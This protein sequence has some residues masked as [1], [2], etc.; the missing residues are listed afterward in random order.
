MIDAIIYSKVLEAKKF[1]VSLVVKKNIDRPILIN[2]LDLAVLLANI[3]D[4]AI[5][6]TMAVESDKVITL[7]LLTDNDNVIILSQNPTINSFV[8]GKLKTT[9]RDK[10]HHGFGTL[11]INSIAEKYNGRYIIDFNNGMAIV[12]VIL[13]NI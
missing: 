11:S 9:K 5:E 4:N 7:S 8:D 12:T 10:K 1:G 2:N 3:L 13:T 6:A